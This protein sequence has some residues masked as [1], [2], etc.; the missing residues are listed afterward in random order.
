[1]VTKDWEEWKREHNG[2]RIQTFSYKINK[3]WESM[4]H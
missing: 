4:Y 2:Q 3:F 1:M